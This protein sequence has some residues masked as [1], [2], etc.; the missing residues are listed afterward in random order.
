MARNWKRNMTASSPIS[1]VPITFAFFIF[2]IGI[3]RKSFLLF[4][5]HIVAVYFEYFYCLLAV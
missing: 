2:S 1:N 3:T 5:A 4:T